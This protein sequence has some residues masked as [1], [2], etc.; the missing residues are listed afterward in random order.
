MILG[1][2]LLTILGLDLKFSDFITGGD[3][4]LKGL[5]NL[6]L[7]WI[8]T[9]SKFKYG[10]Y[11]TGGFFMD[12]Y[13]KEFFESENFHASEKWIYKILGAKY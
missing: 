9:N 12:A 7:T 5:R 2:Y 11:Y 8:Y 4:I 13:V 6:C 1:R 3:G 10:R